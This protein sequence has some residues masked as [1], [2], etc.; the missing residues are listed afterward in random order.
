M[1]SVWSSQ[2]WFWKILDD[3]AAPLLCPPFIH[4]FL[5]DWICQ[6]KLWSW[7]CTIFQQHHSKLVIKVKL[8]RKVTLWKQISVIRT[9]NKNVSEENFFVLAGPQQQ[10]E[11]VTVIH[12]ANQPTLLFLH[13]LFTRSPTQWSMY[14]QKLLFWKSPQYELKA[15]AVCLIHCGCATYQEEL[16]TGCFWKSPSLFEWQFWAA[17]PPVSSG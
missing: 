7:R 4:K 3:L 1:L 8:M 5:P 2:L 16:Q 6:S 12:I 15:N 17:A 13:S 11:T 10:S 14:L 9:I